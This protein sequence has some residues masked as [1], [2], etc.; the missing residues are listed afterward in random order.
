MFCN[1]K[2]VLAWHHRAEGVNDLEAINMPVLK[3]FN[4]ILLI[5][6]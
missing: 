6:T 4:I 2:H 5:P 1:Y 3:F